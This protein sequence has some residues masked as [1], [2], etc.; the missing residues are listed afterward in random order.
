[1]VPLLLVLALALAPQ[2]DRVDTTAQSASVRFEPG[3]AIRSADGDVLGRIESVV[4]GP[5]GRPRQVL[6]RTGGV[7]GVGSS[8]KALPVAGFRTG[9]EGPVAVLTRRELDSLP[10]VAR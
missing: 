1:M 5:D 10:A 2:S 6:V 3:Q 8:I 9:R 7:R 4:A